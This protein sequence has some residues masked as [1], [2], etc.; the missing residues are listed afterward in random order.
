MGQGGGTFWGR[1]VAD[2]ETNRNTPRQDC[3]PAPRTGLR[4]GRRRERE[5]G[6]AV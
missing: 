5:T 6:V 2:L 3:R 1:G 4:G